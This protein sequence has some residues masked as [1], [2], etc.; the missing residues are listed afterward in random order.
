M[1]YFLDISIL[2]T[3]FDE[4]SESLDPEDY[5]SDSSME[6]EVIPRLKSIVITPDPLD[7]TVEKIISKSLPLHVSVSSTQ[8]IARVNGKTNIYWFMHLFIFYFI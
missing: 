4:S 1:C 3:E 5:D 2:P 7:I 6:E 8:P